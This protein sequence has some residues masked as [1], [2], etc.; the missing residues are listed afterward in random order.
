M[1]ILNSGITLDVLV[2]ILFVFQQRCR[3][4]N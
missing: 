4:W 1:S 3:S 2:L